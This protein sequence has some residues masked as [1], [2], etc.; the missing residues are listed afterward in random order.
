M[1]SK[2]YTP[3]LTKS[4]R[5]DFFRNGTDTNPGKN[6]IITN[7]HGRKKKER[8]RVVSNKTNILF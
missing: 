6:K 4:H 2:T 1:D 5:V 3:D 7:K 8:V